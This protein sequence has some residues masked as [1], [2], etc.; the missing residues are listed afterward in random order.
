MKNLIFIL[1]IIIG[2]AACSKKEPCP[3]IYTKENMAGDWHFIEED[4]D[5][6]TFSFKQSGSMS[7]KF[8]GLLDAPIDNSV[9]NVI[10]GQI[11]ASFCDSFITFYSLPNVLINFNLTIANENELLPTE[12]PPIVFFDSKVIKIV[13]SK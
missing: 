5:T 6:T 9:W 11:R 13:R 2:T 3:T 4:N 1:L 8:S 7:L 12:V 10:D